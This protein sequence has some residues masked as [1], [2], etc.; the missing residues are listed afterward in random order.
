MRAVA[1]LRGKVY[2]GE[3]L[4]HEASALDGASGTRPG[5]SDYVLCDP[6]LA[7]LVGCL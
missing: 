2:Q 5:F 6:V 1:H 4:N 7:G 3:A